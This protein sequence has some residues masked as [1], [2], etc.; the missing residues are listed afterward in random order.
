MCALFY[1]SKI[2]TEVDANALATFQLQFLPGCPSPTD[3]DVKRKQSSSISALWKPFIIFAVID[4]NANHWNLSVLVSEAVSPRGFC[5]TSGPHVKRVW[6]NRYLSSSCRR[7]S[8][9]LHVLLHHRTKPNRHNPPPKR[10][11]MVYPTM[12]S[13]AWLA[14][15][16]N[17]FVS[18]IE[19]MKENGKKFKMYF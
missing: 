8:A 14:L 3:S 2:G 10:L 7:H 13:L 4:F 6:P 12:N 15:K 9:V 17:Y 16:N 5:V 19:I 1:F 18:V 11:P